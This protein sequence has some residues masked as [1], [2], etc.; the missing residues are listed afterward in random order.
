MMHSHSCII[1][2]FMFYSLVSVQ[3]F[4]C[5]FYCTLST[6]VC[7]FK[8]K[9][10]YLKSFS[11]TSAALTHTKSYSFMPLYILKDFTEGF[12]DISFNSIYSTLYS[13]SLAKM[14]F[15]WLLTAF[16]DLWSDKNR[17]AKSPQ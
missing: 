17:Y 1:I 5:L 7:R 14:Y 3:T 11:S 15:F 10:I 4:K 9:Y 2:F 6:R 12:V 8:L 16:C 13:K